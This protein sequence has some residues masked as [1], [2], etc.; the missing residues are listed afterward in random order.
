MA[1]EQTPNPNPS[2]PSSS[3]PSRDRQGAVSS[4]PSRDRKGA[5]SSY[6]SRDRKGAVLLG[7]II[8][9]VFAASFCLRSHFNPTSP[10]S[11]AEA[12]RQCRRVVSLAPSVTETLF[13]LG[14]GDRVVAVSKYCTYPREARRR[15]C[16][17]GLFD[18]NMEAILVL[19]PDL[20]IL[21]SP[22][23]GT[24]EGFDRLGIA[25]LVLDHRNPEGVF[26]SISAIGRAC[27]VE[28][29]A[30]ALAGR[31]RARLRRV[32]EKTAG[33]RRPRVLLAVDHSSGG[34]RIEDVYVAG[35]SRYFNPILRWAGG[36]NVFEDTTEAFPVVS[37]E[38][39]LKANPEVIVDLVSAEALPS[40]GV[41]ACRKSWL[42]LPWVAA[43]AADR[44]HVVT[45]DY[46]KVPGPRFILFVERLAQL[47][48][49]EA[50]W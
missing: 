14:L 6:P 21:P 26:D 12:R 2:N 28:A 45:D 49:P 24:V 8:I 50:E 7:A 35:S 9:A 30:D 25:T 4:D 29:D 32:T 3:K 10:P 11:P 46:A 22:E 20:V 5:A 42:E 38:A 19:R 40:G 1:T 44:V 18:P 33:L 16:I 41:E 17:G 34:A 37:R 13:E 47:L 43:V 31:L 23:T 36:K 15:P 48:H 27:A 39:I